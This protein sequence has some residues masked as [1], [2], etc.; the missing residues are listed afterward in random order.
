[1]HAS[2]PRLRGVLALVGA[3]LFICCVGAAGLGTWTFQSIKGGEE[4]ARQAAEAYLGDLVA[5]DLPGAYDR[6][7]TQTRDRLRPGGFAEQV[8]SRPK[9]VRYAI[10]D[11]QVTADNLR[12]QGTVSAEFTWESGVIAPQELSMV[13]EG[14]GWRVCGDPF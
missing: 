5:G 7:C 8:R 12:L 4:P 9:L 10:T 1:M 6:L 11:V 14:G 2:R 13:T 3:V